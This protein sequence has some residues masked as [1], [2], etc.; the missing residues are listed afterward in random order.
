[1]GP[2]ESPTG[3]AE[4]QEGRQERWARRPRKRHCLLKGCEHWFHPRQAHQR[5]C[6]A[7]CQQAARRWSGWKAQRRYRETR[8]GKQKRNGQSQR[9]RERVRRREPPEP[10][11]VT[12]PARVITSEPFFRFF[13]RPTRLLR[14]LRA[15][16][17]S[18]ATLLFPGVSAC[19]GTGP[20]AGTALEKGARLKL[21]ILIHPRPSA[22]IQPVGCIWSFINSTGA[23][24]TCGCA[25]RRGS[26]GC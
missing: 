8:A 9:Y 6:S 2:F 11:A 24:S 21:D 25:I 19:A 3:Q 7:P 18:L 20:R 4:N 14:E 23:G 5:Y 22:Y 26:G 10:E 1:M 17:K 15:R 16:A 13:V 12:D